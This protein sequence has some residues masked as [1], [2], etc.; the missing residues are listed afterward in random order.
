M[1]GSS[2][3]LHAGGC[4]LAR[5]SRSFDSSRFISHRSYGPQSV[6]SD[7]SNAMCWPLAETLRL[8]ARV[9]ET[10]A[11]GQPDPGTAPRCGEHQR[12]VEVLH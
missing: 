8:D 2:P 3:G 11:V 12:D 7:T 9:D 10:R 4:A 5:N 6:D 1:T